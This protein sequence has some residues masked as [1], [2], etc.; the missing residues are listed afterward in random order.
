MDIR[1]KIKLLPI[2]VTFCWVEGNQLQR[3]GRQLYMGE[4]NDKYDYL[5]N[6][7]WLMKEGSNRGPNQLFHH[8]L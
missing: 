4:I 1:I 6:L 5:A 8:S 3:H 2:K 7:F